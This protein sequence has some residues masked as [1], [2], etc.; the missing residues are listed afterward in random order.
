MNIIVDL[1]GTIA[2]CRHRKHFVINGYH[3]WKSFFE[4]MVEDAP[5]QPI[6]NLITKLYDHGDSIFLTTGRPDQY[7]DHTL[8]WLAKNTVHFNVLKMR[9]QYDYREDSIVK[10]EM[11]KEL[12]DEHGNIDLAIDDRQSVVDM[13]RK[14]GIIC[15]QN[16][17]KELS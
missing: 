11:L 16:S 10:Q 9:R 2:D 4:S 17:M 14:N 1:D 12:I 6:I 7:R 5:I 13:W 8:D 15:L 3:D